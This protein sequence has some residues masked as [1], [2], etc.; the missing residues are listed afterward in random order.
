MRKYLQSENLLE[1]V[2]L[3]RLIYVEQTFNFVTRD[4]KA[5]YTWFQTKN[6]RTIT[7]LRTRS[8]GPTILTIQFLRIFS[9]ENVRR[10][11]W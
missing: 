4:Y 8:N 6:K 2:K 11:G 9:V 7:P 3:T 5:I 10:D 1:L